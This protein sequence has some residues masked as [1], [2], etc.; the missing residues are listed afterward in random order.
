MS[1][2]SVQRHL[3]RERLANWLGLLVLLSLVF[4]G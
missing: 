2:R 3:T 1:G 4:A